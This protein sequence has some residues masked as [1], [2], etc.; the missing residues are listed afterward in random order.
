[1]DTTFSNSKHKKRDGTKCHLIMAYMVHK[2][3]YFFR[4]DALTSSTKKLKLLEGRQ[5]TCTLQQ[6]H[7]T[8][9]EPHHMLK[10]I[11]LFCKGIIQNISHVFCIYI[12][13]MKIELEIARNIS[14]SEAKTSGICSSEVS[15]ATSYF[16]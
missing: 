12:R 10:M 1:M 16:R 2:T 4:V 13:C 8:F 6:L 3:S 11:A 7:V 14:A 5:C 9:K 15:H